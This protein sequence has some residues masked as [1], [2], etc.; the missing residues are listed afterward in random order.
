MEFWVRQDARRLPATIWIYKRNHE[1]NCARKEEERKKNFH[2]SLWKLW[3]RLLLLFLC[4]FIFSFLSL[5]FANNISLWL[6]PSNHLYVTITR[7]LMGRRQ[8]QTILFCVSINY[9]LMPNFRR[10][11]SMCLSM[12][13][14]KKKLRKTVIEQQLFAQSSTTW[15]FWPIISR[16]GLQVHFGGDS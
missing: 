7:L 13:G 9:Q 6:K 15:G 8:S 11:L 1:E 4:V 3:L 5:R 16:S 2:Q 10:C 14:K 12:T